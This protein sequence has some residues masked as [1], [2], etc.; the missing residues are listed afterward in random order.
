MGFG[1]YGFG[2]LGFRVSSLLVVLKRHLSRL[3]RVPLGVS[4]NGFWRCR[5]FRGLGF[6]AS[7]VLS[8]GRQG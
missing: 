5:D 7:W 6:R 3:L 2:G 8:L 1:V 4:I